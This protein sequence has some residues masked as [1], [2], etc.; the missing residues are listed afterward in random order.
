MTE[1]PRQRFS[2][3]PPFTFC[4]VDMFGP[5]SIQKPGRRYGV[6]FTCLASRAVHIE[7]TNPLET[8]I[9]ALSQ[10]LARLSNECR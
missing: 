5:F 6:I 4:G 1:F 9:L 7:T 3:S 2:N 10:F 8:F